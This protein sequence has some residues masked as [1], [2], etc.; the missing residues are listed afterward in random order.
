M[1]F[2]IESKSMCILGRSEKK[3][4]QRRAVDLKLLGR[5]NRYFL[6]FHYSRRVY[7]RGKRQGSLTNL[8]L[9]TSRHETRPTWAILPIYL[10]I[11]TRILKYIIISRSTCFCSPFFLYTADVSPTSICAIFTDSDRLTT[12]E[13]ILRAIIVE[14]AELD[15]T[16]RYAGLRLKQN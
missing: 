1:K 5:T 3:Y 8:I 11:Y 16:C 15:T 6:V 7:P 10:A 2:E 14:H 9:C 4:S 13:S 12:S